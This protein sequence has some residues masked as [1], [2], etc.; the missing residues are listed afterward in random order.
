MTDSHHTHSLA[1]AQT[2]AE[3]TAHA[4]WSRDQAA[5]GLGMALISVRPGMPCSP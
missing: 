2:L 5:R 1:E 4:M 3:A